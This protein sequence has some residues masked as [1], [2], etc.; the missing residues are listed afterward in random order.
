MCKEYVCSLN[1]SQTNGQRSNRIHTS[2]RT[3]SLSDLCVSSLDLPIP[4]IGVQPEPREGHVACITSKY[5]I[6]R[7][8][9]AQ[10]GTKRLADVQV[11]D[12]YSP[13]WECLDEGA[14]ISAMPWAKQRAVYTCFYGNKLYTIK[15]NMQEKLFEL[16]VGLFS[17]PAIHEILTICPLIS[18]TK[19]STSNH[20]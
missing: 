17:P 1:S 20:K 8:G 4:Q 6:I 16:Q 9:C 2:P 3:V 14:Y 10:G 7:G 11:L 18:P 13:R 19:L 15:G 5:L 12:L